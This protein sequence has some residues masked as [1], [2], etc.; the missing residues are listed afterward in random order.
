M[1]VLASLLWSAHSASSLRYPRW[2]HVSWHISSW[3]WSISYSL[4][5]LFGIL[6]LLYWLRDLNLSIL[7][8]TSTTAWKI[9]FLISF[10]IL[11]FFF[12]FQ[13]ITFFISSNPFQHSCSPKLFFCIVRNDWWFF[14]FPIFLE[15][16]SNCCSLWLT[17][18][19]S[20]PLLLSFFLSFQIIN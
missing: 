3:Y 10:D 2:S 14:L 8:R 9:L 16:L 1:H 4:M 5:N 17:I 6:L 12:L 11:S 18:F 7:V 19:V 20:V 15:A 13:P